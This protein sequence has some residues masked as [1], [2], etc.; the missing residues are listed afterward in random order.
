M[1]LDSQ[2]VQERSVRNYRQLKLPVQSVGAHIAIDDLDKR[3]DVGRQHGNL[4][5]G[6]LQHRGRSIQLHDVEPF[7]G[8]K[9]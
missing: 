7:S 8:N 3:A 4:G 2:Q 6:N 5:S 9:L 1:I